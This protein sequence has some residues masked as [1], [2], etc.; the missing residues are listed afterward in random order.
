MVS[1][2]IQLDLVKSV[3]MQYECSLLWTC[4]FLS[5]LIS[6]SYEVYS[7]SALVFMDIGCVD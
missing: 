1:Q 4:D 2:W 5:L 7:T 3:I 6:A